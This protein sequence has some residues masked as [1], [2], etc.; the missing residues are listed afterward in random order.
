M[1]R[2]GDE[3]MAGD[4]ARSLADGALVAVGIALI[5]DAF[6]GSGEL[7]AILVRGPGGAPLPP[8]AGWSI[9][10]ALLVRRRFPT[11][12]LVVCAA[13]AA[14]ALSNAV[15]FWRI[16]VAGGI[17]S[18]FPVPLSLLVAALFAGGA[19]TRPASAASGGA[20]WI[21]LAAAGP[22][23]LLLHIAT[24]GSTDYRRPAEA[25]VVFGARPGS[26]A[27]HDRTREGARLWKEGL[28]PR[29]VL[30]GAPDEVDDMAAIARRE[31]VP[32]S[33]IVRDDAG[34]NTAATLR[35]LRSRRVLAVSHDY[36][37]A[38]IKLAA[39]RMGIECATVPCA[40][41]RPLTRKAW[42]VARE[43]AAF[44]Y[45]YLFRRA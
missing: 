39:G 8:L 3:E 36:H 9:G 25:I 7:L 24:L 32:D 19:R 45:Y 30:S 5:F 11:A 22:A 37:L 38:R 20:R 27:L 17:R 40:E 18:A 23:A 1:G 41:T 26:L 13:T 44:P 28:A 15:D 34:V 43:V 2:K 10:L 4:R 29:L 33:A 35:N 14:L 21:A 12:A 16:V 42:Y 6:S 31:K